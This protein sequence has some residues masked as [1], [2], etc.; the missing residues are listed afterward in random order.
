MG[1]SKTFKNSESKM[2]TINVDGLRSIGS[3]GTITGGNLPHLSEWEINA[4][5][6][7]EA[8]RQAIK[9]ITDGRL[10]ARQAARHLGILAEK[11]VKK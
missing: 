6:D 1:K 4:D 2:E 3:I 11:I 10:T 8:K 5:I 7:P 9:D